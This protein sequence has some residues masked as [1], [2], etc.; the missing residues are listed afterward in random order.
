MKV[1]LGALIEMQNFC[2]EVQNKKIPIRL[3]YTISKLSARVNEEETFYRQKFT[4]IVRE[5]AKL[6]DNG[7]FIYTEDGSS[8]QIQAGRINECQQRIQ[9]LQDIEV[10]VN[11]ISF[12]LTELENLDLTVA[13]LSVLMPLIVE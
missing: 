6:D 3:A 11:D 13:E 8:V 10:E 2:Q 4:E 12:T 1:K 5:C 9:E 7:N